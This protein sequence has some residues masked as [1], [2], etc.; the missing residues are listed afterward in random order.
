MIAHLIDF[1][2]GFIFTFDIA[3]RTYTLLGPGD[4]GDLE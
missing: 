1:W 3:F 2:G 4:K